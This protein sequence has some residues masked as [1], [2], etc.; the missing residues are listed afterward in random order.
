MMKDKR[1]ISIN[2]IDTPLGQMVA[3][4][5][6]DAVCLLEFVDRQ[7][8]ERQMERVDRYVGGVVV[9]REN[10]ILRKLSRELNAYFEGR[11]TSF[12]TPLDMRGTPFQE[13]VWRELLTVPYGMTR[14]YGELAKGLGS[15]QSVR[16]V[17]RA[18]GD[19]RIAI[20][21]PCH[22]I[23]GA[24]GKLTGYGGGLWRKERLLDLEKQQL[25][26]GL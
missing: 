23:I 9:P 21:I 19:N 5:T 7:M 16:A 6:E 26:L 22:R 20:L 14:S 18:N 25:V 8:I 24:D 1:H 13:R 17:A 11:L 12:E 4:A 15:P 10:D 3:C 2:R